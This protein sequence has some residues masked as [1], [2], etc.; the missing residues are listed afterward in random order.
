MNN[1]ILENF[2]N[3]FIKI[4]NSSNIKFNDEIFKN[5][6]YS[7][8]FLMSDEEFE[9]YLDDIQEKSLDELVKKYF[10]DTKLAY[11]LKEL[12]MQKIILRRVSK[13]F[14]QNFNDDKWLKEYCPLC[15]GKAGIGLINGEG[16]R[17]LVCVDCSMKW[18]FRRAV[19]PFCL[20]ESGKYNLFELN[21]L[22]IRVEFCDKC[23][24]YLKTI[25]LNEEKTPYEF[26]LQ[27]LCIDIWAIKKGYTKKTASM[28]GINFFKEEPWM[29]SHEEAF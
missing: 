12:L 21:E 8:A 26:D 1:S 11:R 22:S 6:D 5:Y 3:E 4:E 24:G 23:K 17:Y 16:V 19:C 10:Y 18:R 7:K 29:D 14:R 15:G 27:T 28:I 13:I 20:E 9:A 2:L 25:I